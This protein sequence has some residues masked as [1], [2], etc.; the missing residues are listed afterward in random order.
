LDCGD[1][2]PRKGETKLPKGRRGYP[3]ENSCRFA[4]AYGR[5]EPSD[6]FPEARADGFF[7]PNSPVNDPPSC[8]PRELADATS[9]GSGRPD[10]GA[11]QDSG[12]LRRGARA[13]SAAR[14][15]ARFWTLRFAG[16]F[17]SVIPASACQSP[18][19]RLSRFR[20]VSLR[21]PASASLFGP[22]PK[23]FTREAAPKIHLR[24]TV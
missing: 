9:P 13:R 24:L 17:R 15:A 22:R 14:T 3:A 2:R 1:I 19:L 7:V 5:T 10:S 23:L 18:C 20:A 16:A 11:P 12:R 4:V 21:R 6:F 8:L